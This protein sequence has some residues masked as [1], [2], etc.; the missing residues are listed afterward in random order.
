[1][2]KPVVA[3]LLLATGC[4]IEGTPEADTS[5][6]EQA[7]TNKTVTNISVNGRS[8]YAALLDAEGTNGFLAATE[9][10]IAQT[11]GLDFSWATPDPL[12]PLSAILYQGAGEIPAGAFTYSGTSAHLNLTTPATYPVT[13]CVIN[14]DDGTYTCAPSGPLTFNMTWTANG[15]GR[16]EEKVKRKEVLGPVTTKLTAEYTMLS[17]NVNG[18]WGGRSSP[19]LGGDLTDSE[20]KTYIREIT[21]SN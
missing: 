2:L 18:T 10:Q 20:S 11:F 12:N 16:V 15:F 3:V 7:A 8:T 21:V 13:R 19:N 5:S 9:D 14:L 1:M 17:A 4:S 6:S